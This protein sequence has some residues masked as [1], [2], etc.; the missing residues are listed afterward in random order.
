M[1][2]LLLITVFGLALATQSMAQSQKAIKINYLQKESLAAQS[3][4]DKEQHRFEILANED[5]DVNLK[6]SLKKEDN[7]NIV[8]T[9]D[10]DRVVL[11]KKLRKKGENSLAFSMSQ[12]E[13]YI[14]K[15]D[16]EK[17]SNLTVC[18]TED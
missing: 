11:T 5:L 13:K 17:K 16:G 2:H 1:K 15:L 12:N 8:V 4:K 18:L 9:D 7:I 6:F 10:K 14:V 3:F